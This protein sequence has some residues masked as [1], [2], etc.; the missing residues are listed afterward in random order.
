[1]DC[2]QAGTEEVFCF[3]QEDSDEL[4]PEK[5]ESDASADTPL[6][7]VPGD[8]AVSG[9][10]VVLRATTFFNAFTASWNVFRIVCMNIFFAIRGCE[11]WIVSAGTVRS[12]MSTFGAGSGVVA[13][14][15]IAVGGSRRLASVIAE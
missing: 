15:D 7:D 10:D 11:E 2:S 5:L 1:M 14:K 12:W 6:C 4:V 13:G 9:C 3:A 8:F